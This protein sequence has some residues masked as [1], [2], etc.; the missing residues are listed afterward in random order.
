MGFIRWI[1]NHGIRSACSHGCCIYKTRPAR[2]IHIRRWRIPDDH[3]GAGDHCSVQTSCED[4]PAQQPIPGHGTG[5]GRSS[6]L[7]VDM[8]VPGLTNPDFSKIAEGF[9]VPAMKI[10]ERSELDK[11]LDDLLAKEGPCLL[12]IEVQKEG[13][14]FPMVPS[15][16]YC[17]R[18]TFRVIRKVSIEKMKK[19]YTI[20]VFSEH[21]VGLLHRITVIFST[22]EN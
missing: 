12:E 10:T 17:F 6:F 4:D 3:P 15:G 22:K 13:N 16:G 14:I 18:Y 11:A 2:S 7:T 1:G 19:E 5:S 8:P 9:G 21:K 20:S